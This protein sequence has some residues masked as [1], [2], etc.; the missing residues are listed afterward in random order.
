M[1]YYTGSC[2]LNLGQHQS[3]IVQLNECITLNHKYSP[4]AYLLIAINFKLLKNVKQAI[5]VLEEGAGVF[6]NSEEVL[7]YKGKLQ[8]RVGQAREAVE[9]FMQC[10]KANPHNELATLFL[11]DSLKASGSPELAQ[12]HYTALCRRGKQH[13]NVAALRLAGL[14]VEGQKWEP[15]L[16]TL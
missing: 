10:L 15:A 12:H 11:G 4:S 5:R 14:Y 13:R 8:M 16:K 7:F 9:C 3:S 1:S 2:L 6:P